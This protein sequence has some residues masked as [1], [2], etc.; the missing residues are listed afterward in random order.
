M[1]VAVL[2]AGH[3]IAN[4]GP[5]AGLLPDIGGMHHRHG[6]FLPADGIDFLPHDGFNPVQG[7]A[8]QGQVGEDP[9]AELADETRPQQ[10]LMAGCFSIGW[11][12]PQ[13]G[14]EGLGEAH[15]L[16]VAFR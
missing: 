5:A 11:H 3:L 10:K 1:A 12:L 16:V 2:E 4:L 8:G 7:A 13:G 9:R 14:A 15:A 6:Q